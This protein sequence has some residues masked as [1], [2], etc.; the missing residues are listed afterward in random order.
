MVRGGGGRPAQGREE[1]RRGE[2]AADSEGRDALQ[3]P[4]SALERRPEG[5]RTIR[6]AR[7]RVFP[8]RPG[9]LFPERAKR[10]ISGRPPR[11]PP[12]SRP[13]PPPHL[14]PLVPP[15]PYPESA[16]GPPAAGVS[17]RR[18][19]ATKTR[20][21]TCFWLKFPIS[22][23]PRPDKSVPKLRLAWTRECRSMPC[24]NAAGRWPPRAAL[25]AHTVSLSCQ[26]PAQLNFAL[27]INWLYT[28][29]THTGYTR[30]G[31][32]LT[33]TWLASK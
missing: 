2:V 27:A 10:R 1:T 24:F 22:R 17:A 31:T 21:K 18:G 13:P 26:R 32:S 28:G 15:H 30:A 7:P 14:P 19:P 4:A 20:H 33:L 3:D 29:Y 16:Q 9:R 23:Y 25:T 5:A 8:G 11:S 6:P 12:R